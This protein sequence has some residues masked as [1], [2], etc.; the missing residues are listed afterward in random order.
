[1]PP[2]ARQGWSRLR[3]LTLRNGHLEGVNVTDIA[4]D[5]RL[6]D[7]EELRLTQIGLDDQQLNEF[8]SAMP[9]LRAL[10][11]SESNI[12]GVGVKTAIKKTRIKD[13]NLSLCSK[14]SEDAVQWARS[15]GVTVRRKMDHN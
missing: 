7:L 12:T 9:K 10:D 11:V 14:V 4:S 13:L 6:R 3:S 2:A 5:E 8:V 1:M 15:E